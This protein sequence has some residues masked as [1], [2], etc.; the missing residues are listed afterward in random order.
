MRRKITVI[1][2]GNVGATTALFLA[3]KNLGNVVLTDIV[4]DM[5]QGKA[6]DMLETGPVHGYHGIITGTNDYADIT[7]SDVVVVTAGL[8]R[9]PGMSRSD[10]L[11]MNAEIVR[12][13]CGNIKEYAPDSIVVIVSN[14]LDIMCWVAHETT[15]FDKNR[16]FGMAGVLDT[17]RMRAF[18]AEA[19]DCHA[20]DV[21]C[22]V[23]GGHGDSMVPITSTTSVSGVPLTDLLPQ[24]KIDAIV[25]RTRKGGGEIVKLLKTGSAFY[26]PAASVVD[27]VESILLDSKRILPCAALLEGE[28]GISGCY[29]GVPVKLGSKG[30]EQVI[31]M[32]LRND[33]QA[34]L[35]ESADAVLKD[36][37]A[38]ATLA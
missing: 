20:A 18:I 38:L 10:L 2:G 35:K 16:V 7:G 15:G 6:L 9:K 23:L 28:Y 36:I 4:E 8:P 13:V 19:A 22:M 26:A 34:A 37:E 21:T 31:E 25:E 33:E 3:E 11:G 27:M 30:I 29:I 32:K 14:P 1:G 12:E 17:S 5:P 24:D